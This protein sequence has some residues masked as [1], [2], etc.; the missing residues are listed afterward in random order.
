M[1]LNELNP[2]L[3]IECW[4]YAIVYKPPR[5]Y[6]EALQNIKTCLKS[7]SRAAGTSG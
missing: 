4:F 6:Q 1:D 2:E 7:G 5:F 3:A